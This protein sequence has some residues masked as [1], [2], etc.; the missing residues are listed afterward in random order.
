MVVLAPLRAV[1]EELRRSG[2]VESVMHDAV[3]AFAAWLESTSWGVMA[4]ESTWAYPFVQLIHFTGL[5]IWL[6]TTFALDLRVGSGLSA[7]NRRATRARALCVELDRVF[8]RA[9]P[10]D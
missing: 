1:L 4:R 6:G 7:L 8:Y 5:S 9:P 2:E 10:G 3:A